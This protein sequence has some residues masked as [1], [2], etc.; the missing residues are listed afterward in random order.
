MAITPSMSSRMPYRASNASAL[1]GVD[2]AI[3]VGGRV[4]CHH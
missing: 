4:E 1:S 3:S 2:V